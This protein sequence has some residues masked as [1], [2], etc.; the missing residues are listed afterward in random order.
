[1]A[2]SKEG[3]ELDVSARRFDDRD[4][5]S[6]AMQSFSRTDFSERMAEA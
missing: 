5:L 2:A 6:S 1:M 4:S 3:F